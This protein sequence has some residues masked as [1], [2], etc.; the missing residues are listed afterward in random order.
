MSAD[1]LA[2]GPRGR[3]NPEPG[4]Q[5]SLSLSSP[6]RALLQVLFSYSILLLPAP[7]SSYSTSASQL[8]LLLPLPYFFARSP[9]GSTRLRVLLLHFPA[10]CSQRQ[11]FISR[12]LVVSANSSFS[13]DRSI[14]GAFPPSSLSGGLASEAPRFFSNKL[15]SLY[16][17]RLLCAW[18]GVVGRLSL[19]PFSSFFLS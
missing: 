5:S 12:L 2:A 4:Q 10:A 6:A 3:K 8:V 9:G 13:G 17:S 11:F 18:T 16:L 19:P 14:L 7:S 1:W 15:L